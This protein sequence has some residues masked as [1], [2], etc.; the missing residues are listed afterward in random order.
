MRQA[1]LFGARNRDG[2]GIGLTILTA[3]GNLL[4]LLP[5]EETHLALFHGCA[6]GGGRLRR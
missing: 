5:E 2:W 3:L 4:P 1:A 6:A